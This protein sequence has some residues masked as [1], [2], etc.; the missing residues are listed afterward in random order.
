MQNHATFFEQHGTAIQV[1]L[2]AGLLTTLWVIELMVSAEPVGIKWNHARTNVALMLLALP[3]QLVMTI[4]VV[5]AA[6][7]V[8]AHHWGLLQVLP[9]SSSIWSK[10][11]LA[12]VLMDLGDYV[13]HV[14]MHKT[15]WFW[16]FHLVHHC[17]HDVDVSTTIREHPG[18]TFVRVSFLAVWVLL[19]GAGWGVLLLRQTVETISNITSHSKYRVPGRLGRILGWIF[20][21]PNLHHVH[22]HFQQP[23][24]DSNFGDVF[25]IWDRLFGTYA[26][27][28]TDATVFGVDTH[29]DRHVT[30]SFKEIVM[31][32]F[33]RPVRQDGAA[34]QFGG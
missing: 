25:S 10:Y 34:K 9:G 33:R 5:M 11:V 22:H 6:S 1:V 15:P 18:D 7:W 32:P 17:A 2:Y 28:S 12:F 20:I 16:R 30:E 29:A 23:Y 24:T 21:T 14:T 4:F 26:E 13:Y 3:V 27:L 19:V 8:T 31:I